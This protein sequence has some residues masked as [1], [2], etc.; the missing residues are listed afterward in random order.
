M[1]ETPRAAELQALEV[2]HRL[3][4]AREARRGVDAW[5]RRS[6]RRTRRQSPTPGRARARR[7][8]RTARAVRERTRA[9]IAAAVPRPEIHDGDYVFLSFVM[10]NLPRGLIGLLL[11]VILC[12]AMSSTASELTALGGCTVV[13]FYRR[14]FRPDATD[15]HYLRVAKIATGVWGVLAV[16]FAGFASLVDNLIQAVNILG[17]L[18]YGTILG[19]FLVAF[20]FRRLRATPV[21]VAAHRSPRCWWCRALAAGPDRIPLV[22]R[23]RLRRRVA[24]VIA[25]ERVRLRPQLNLR[26]GALPMKMRSPAPD[27]RGGHVGLGAVRRAPRPP[28]P[29]RPSNRFQ[30]DFLELLDDVQKKILSLEDAMPQD[31]FKWRPS[32]GVRSVSEAFLHIAYGNYGFTK[33]A[34]G[35]APPADVGWGTDHAKWDTKTTDKAEIKKTL[36]SVVRAGAA[37]R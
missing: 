4:F 9:L 35:K 36:E 23:D 30:T 37:R 5:R 20:F 28:R 10:A 3:A 34:T 26:P 15:A 19:I 2:E 11:A 31:K 21:F 16:A 12:A 27:C 24:L 25:A 29:P 32:P 7:P 22:Q 6:T 1:A 18:F 33:G 14:S 17:S 8:P 13:D